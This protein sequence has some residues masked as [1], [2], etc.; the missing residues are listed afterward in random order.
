MD[1][2]TFVIAVLVLSGVQVL[3]SVLE[4]VGMPPPGW[5]DP[6]VLL[7]GGGLSPLW[8]VLLVG[9][10]LLGREGLGWL[11]RDALRL[12]GSGWL[13]LL[14]VVGP[15]ASVVLSLVLAGTRPAG[16]D[17]ALGALVAQILL[18]A[19]LFALAENLGWRTWLQRGLQAHVSP[20]L[21]GVLVGLVWGVWHAP[22]FIVDLG[23][24]HQRLPFVTYLVLL[25]AFSVLLAGLFNA[26]RGSV[27][28]VVVAHVSFNA[29]LQLSIPSQAD[30]AALLLGVAAVVF[31]VAVV[32]WAWGCAPG[33]TSSAPMDP[34]VG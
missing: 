5:L 16:A 34:H 7:I 30:E 29:T 8:A 13:Y 4:R 28:P 18:V 25:V 26:A 14:A 1:V 3:P 2:T 20:L 27:L 11:F 21:A 33:S 15:A 9:G 12:Q 10:V 23:T 6:I 19:P 22:L 17:V 24:V 31:W 32:A